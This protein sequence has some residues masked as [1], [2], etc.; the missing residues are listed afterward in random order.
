MLRSIARSLIYHLRWFSSHSKLLFPA[1]LNLVFSSKDHLSVGVSW[2]A[3]ASPDVRPRSAT[4]SARG[5]SCINSRLAKSCF[6][7]AQS[8]GMYLTERTS[9]SKDCHSATANLNIR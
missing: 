5:A 7:H 1:R 2:G 3:G 9:S 4:P 8:L 6:L